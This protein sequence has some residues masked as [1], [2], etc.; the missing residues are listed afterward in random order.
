MLQRGSLGTAPWQNSFLLQ[1]SMS[2]LVS[3]QHTSCR[4]LMTFS[5][6]SSYTVQ[7]G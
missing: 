4:A 1:T 5:M 7:T 3:I 6:Y 2:G